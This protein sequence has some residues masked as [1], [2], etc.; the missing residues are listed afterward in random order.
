MFAFGGEGVLSS[1]NFEEKHM[2]KLYAEF[3]LWK[4]GFHPGEKYEKLL[5]K[6]FL[7]DSNNDFLLELEE[8]STDTLNTSEHFLRYWTYKHHELDTNVFGKYLFF[9]LN[10]VYHS[11]TI[12]IEDFGNQCYLLWKDFPPPLDHIE[13]FWTLSYADDP[14]SWGDEAQTRGLYEKAFAF[15]D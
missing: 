8:C 6:M 14:L 4:H 11:T 1:L 5:N 15:Y 7:S 10:L 2:E 13:P 9:S 12:S 3:L